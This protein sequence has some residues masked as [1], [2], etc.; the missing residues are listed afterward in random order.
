[1]KQSKTTTNLLYYT[2]FLEQY[3][4]SVY[5]GSRRHKERF[6]SGVPVRSV[7]R[8]KVDSSRHHTLK[9]TLQGVGNEEVRPTGHRSN[10]ARGP[11]GS[12]EVP[13]VV[14][15]RRDE[16]STNQEGF[17]LYRRDRGS[18]ENLKNL[19]GKIDDGVPGDWIS[20]FLDHQTC[21]SCP[22]LTPLLTRP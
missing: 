17:G 11:E 8:P 15:S 16:K 6:S 9:M 2:P 18:W 14:T 3:I 4:P 1:M 12:S 21:E 13:L 19:R 7:S 22:K 5:L 10:L 20:F